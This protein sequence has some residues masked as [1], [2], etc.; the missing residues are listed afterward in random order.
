MVIKLPLD[1][2]YLFEPLFIIK[3]N[4]TNKPGYW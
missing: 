1:A 4:A 2:T 3:I